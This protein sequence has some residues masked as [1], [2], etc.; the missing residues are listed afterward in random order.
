VSPHGGVKG[1][2]ARGVDVRGDGG[3]IIWYE[4]PSDIWTWADW[5]VRL[6]PAAL[7]R[8]R[9]GSA[10]TVNLDELAPPSAADLL[11]LLMSMSNPAETPRDDYVA[12]NLAVVGCLRALDD[13]DSES[14]PEGIANAIMDAAA[15]WSA[16]WDSPRASSFQAERDRWDNDWLLRD[17]DVS[18]WRHVLGHAARLG[19]DVSAYRIADAQA[20]FQ[21]V[22]L[23]PADALSAGP[24]AAPVPPARFEGP[25]ELTEESA[26][27]AFVASHR[28]IL[29]FDE[30]SRTWA[31]LKNGIWHRNQ[32]NAALWKVRTYI[33]TARA[34]FGDTDKPAGGASFS[35]HVEQA[36]RVDP[37]ITVSASAWD[38]DPMLLGTPAGVFDLATGELVTD[39]NRDR[40]TKLTGVA[41]APRGTD[42]PIWSQF[43]HQATGDDAA[44]IAWLQRAAG[45]IITGSMIE[46]IFFFFYG[47]AGTGKGTWLRTI[48]RILGDYAYQLPAELFDARS[49]V[50][51][52]YQRAK[53]AGRRAAFASETE[54]GNQLAE[55]LIK[56]LTG[57][58]G[59]INAREPYGKPFEFD[60][61]A[62]LILVSNHAPRLR[63]GRSRA[64][65]RRLRLVPF[66]HPPATPDTA[67]KAALE[68]EYPAI[69][70][71]VLDGCLAWQRNGIGT[72][73]AVARATDD[74]FQDQ[75][76]IGQWI[77]ERID[78][79]EK[80][81]TNRTAL[82]S[83]FTTW[84]HG[85][86]EA[87]AKT[88]EF[89]EALRRRFGITEKPVRGVR[90]FPTVGLRPSPPAPEFAAERPPITEADDIARV[91]N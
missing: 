59:K 40:V 37:L 2:V 42:H 7:P 80:L 22:A 44:L 13:P 39:A 18:G 38:T 54:A 8:T 31:I 68:T 57:N 56:E 34:A 25:E 15:E 1:Q 71:W 16:S 88:G 78:I 73:D 23:P 62:K 55:G 45:Y 21:A 46:E 87:P 35:R 50:N 82:Y 33:A 81:S 79:G 3:Y 89:Y 69:L 4:T 72:C 66:E 19:V 47:D 91:L 53:L 70:R 27:R 74:Y 17:H 12:V 24:V 43:L 48:A 11:T 28:G 83:D 90:Y 6:L 75:D 41:P 10:S 9:P 20:E 63:G 29:V 49:R 60:A 5:P 51:P 67:L 84:A 32:C 76:T 61:Q 26:A 86:G 58:E 64:M 30:T 14:D 52:E 36:S 85:A 65:E 77:K